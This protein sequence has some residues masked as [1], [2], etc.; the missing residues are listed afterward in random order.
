MDNETILK[1]ISQ[2]QATLDEI[3]TQIRGQTPKPN[4]PKTAE[5][6]V[7]P[8]ELESLVKMEDSGE[9]WTVTPTK[10]LGSDNFGMILNITKEYG[11]KYLPSQGKGQ[12]GYFEIPK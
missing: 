3:N 2:I 11:G 9:F 6:P 7:F 4:T 10:F 1:K 12:P 8:Q 5:K